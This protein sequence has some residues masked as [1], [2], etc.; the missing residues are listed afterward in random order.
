MHS[1]LCNKNANVMDAANEFVVGLYNKMWGKTDIS[2]V[3][4]C[5]VETGKNAANPPFLEYLM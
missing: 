3:D 5:R 4:V 1:F 2:Y